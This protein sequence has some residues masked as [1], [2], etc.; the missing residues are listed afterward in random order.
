ML[1]VWFSVTW[2]LLRGADFMRPS[3]LQRMYS[4]L[5][6][7]VVSWLL[8]LGDA[9]LQYSIALA[10]GYFIVFYFAATFVALTISYL[11]LFALPTKSAYAN[12]RSLE[13]ATSA[14]SQRATVGS[15]DDDATEN[16]S[17]L[18]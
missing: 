9:I 14:D 6:L 17:L 4:L 12:L 2:F 3:A 8:L 7:F 10:G 13:T 18:H 16:T 5:W 11:E 15:E 1:S